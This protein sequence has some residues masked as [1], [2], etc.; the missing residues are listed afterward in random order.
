MSY[1]AP[2]INESEKIIKEAVERFGKK[3]AIGFSGGTDSLVVLNMALSYMWDIPVVFVDTNYQ[4]PETYD[5]IDRIEKEW[6]LNLLRYKAGPNVD[7]YK[8]TYG[9][10][11]PEFYLECCRHHKIGPMMQS[12]K[13]L[14][15]EAFMV[16]IRGCEHPTRAE[17]IPFSHKPD[18]DYPHWRVH[19]ILD[20]SMQDVIDYTLLYNIPVN[21]LYAQ[22]YTSLG[23]T[24]CTSKNLTPGAHERA[25]RARGRELIKRKMKEEGYN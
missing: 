15:L 23:C 21:P 11:T 6:N 20:W 18:F 16:G 5:F 9:E 7:Y 2:K 22:G 10:A 8:E 17:E 14:G 3:M 13:N 1:L 12:I 19:P 4:F 24:H 25:G